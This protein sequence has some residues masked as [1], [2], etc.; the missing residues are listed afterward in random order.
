MHP[1]VP[2]LGNEAR[3]SDSRKR[4]GRYLSV[5]QSKSGAGTDRALKGSLGT[6]ENKLPS[7][8]SMTTIGDETML[9]KTALSAALALGALTG[10]ANDAHAEISANVALVNDYRFR[11]IS[12]SNENPAVQ[13][14]FDYG[15][16]NGFYVGTWGST[17][18]FDS[19][20]DFNG[21]LELDVY[22][23]WGT[24]FG[25][26]SSIDVGYIY[27]AYPGDD[28][29]LDGDYQEIYVNYGWRDLSLGAAYS[30]DYFGGSGK[31]WYL[32]ANYD[33]GFAE[34]WT[35]SLHVG[36]NDFDEDIF[37]S[38]DKGN[39]TDYSVG[40]T[41]SVVGVDL[42]LSWV[43]T[44]LKEEDVFGYSWGDDTAVFSL[45]KSF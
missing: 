4:V 19:T 6:V 14:G 38:S 44:N 32:Q 33:W 13:G 21:S 25:E 28:N 5:F 30:N 15:F 34:D 37:L 23:G 42:G 2:A 43:G 40:V 41:W 1:F 3:S 18:D 20:T 35:L 27:Y 26:N 29:G 12:Q 7:I 39:Y 36:Y 22:G 9:K 45:S 16:E 10:A 24:E 11:G 31:F 17:V 8:E